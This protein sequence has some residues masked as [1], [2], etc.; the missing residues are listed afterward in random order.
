MAQI[1]P[2]DRLNDF[3][4]EQPYFSAGLSTP[5]EKRANSYWYWRAGTRPG[6]P[7]G[8]PVNVRRA[9]GRSGANV[10]NSAKASQAARRAGPGAGPA[11]ARALY[12]QIKGELDAE[13]GATCPALSS[14]TLDLIGQMIDDDAQLSGIPVEMSG[15]RRKTRGKR[16]RG[17]ARFYDEL[18]R[19]LRILCILPSEVAKEMDRS[20]AD[21]LQP[22]GDALLDPAV[23]PRIATVVR[24][25]VFPGL[26]T[27]GLVR[28]LGT[29]GSYTVRAIN[30]IIGSI[31]YFFN[32]RLTA[33]WYAAFIGN[34]ASLIAGSGPTLVSL[35]A[36][37]VMNYEGVRVF[38]GLYNR[39][40]AA[41][42]GA[43]ITDEQLAVAFEGT[44]VQYVNY[45]SARALRNS[46]PRLPAL[47]QGVVNRG[48]PQLAAEALDEQLAAYMEAVPAAQAPRR[49][50]SAAAMM[51]L[52]NG[53]AGAGAGQGPAP[54][55]S[56]GRRKTRKHRSRRY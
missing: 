6:E 28:D 37:V 25:R 44:V 26:L 10:S 14:E 15:G 27:L 5:V 50:A 43:A 18:K 36:V 1:V 13:L 20:G 29:N 22:V 55:S 9:N 41:Y 35:A 42:Q 19:V 51:A 34:A 17:G 23:A 56:G 7:D 32:P 46:Y 30:A 45:L 47:L 12:A 3:I 33:G 40:L 49:R 31:G 8:L 2:G 54:A 39:A 48:A 53:P 24:T 11:A 52:R 38:Q 16:Q 21:A 4:R